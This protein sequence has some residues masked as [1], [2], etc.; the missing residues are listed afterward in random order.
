MNYTLRR[1]SPLSDRQLFVAAYNWL[2]TSPQWRRDS[3][4]AF[5][6][7]DLP[8]YLKAAGEPARVCT[9][10]LAPDL[11]ALISMTVTGRNAVEVHLEAKRGTDAEVVVAAGCEVRDQLFRYGIDY[12]YTW[13]PRWNRRVCNINKAIGFRPDNVSMWRGSTGE[14]TIEWLRYSIVNPLCR[15]A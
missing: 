13:I 4:A 14:R 5:G 12:G 15:A 3:E 11:C 9:G 2:A 10:V 1:I 6:V 8:S 7:T